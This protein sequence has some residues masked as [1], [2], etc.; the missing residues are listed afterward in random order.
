MHNIFTKT[1]EFFSL[2]FLNIIIDIQKKISPTTNLLTRVKYVSCRNE[3]DEQA[4]GAV[5]CQK[6]EDLLQQS[7]F[8]MLTM[9]LTPQTYKLVGKK[10]LEL[11]KPTAILINICRGIV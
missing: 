8:V 6:I 9:R 1:S 10:E 4:V 5:Y 2:V 7:D 11:M 3:A